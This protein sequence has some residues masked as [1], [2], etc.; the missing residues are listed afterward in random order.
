[1]PVSGD[2]RPRPLQP[3]QNTSSCYAGSHCKRREGEQNYLHLFGIETPISVRL[4][5]SVAQGSINLPKTYTPPPISRRQQRDKKQVP[6]GEPKILEYPMN[7][8]VTWSFLFGAYA[9]IHV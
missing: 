2:A 3:R 6:Q 5:H 8:T 9:V 4:S 7:L 1:M